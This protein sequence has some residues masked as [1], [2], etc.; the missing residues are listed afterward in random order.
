MK[1]RPTVTGIGVAGL[2]TFCCRQHLG[3]LRKLGVINRPAKINVE[4]TRRF[5]RLHGPA[6]RVVSWLP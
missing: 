1:G 4:R 2:T 3:A 6:G 5:R